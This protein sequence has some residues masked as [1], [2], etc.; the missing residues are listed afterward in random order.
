MT[1]IKDLYEWAVKNNM[2][3]L[4][5]GL[6]FQDEDEAY[7][8]NTFTEFPDYR[9]SAFVKEYFGKKYILLE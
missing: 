4:P 9:I 6:Q 1:T 2:E 5:V 3:N 7:S 8:G